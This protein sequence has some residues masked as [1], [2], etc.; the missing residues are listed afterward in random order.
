MTRLDEA[1]VVTLEWDE[2]DD[3][4]VFADGH[5]SYEIDENCEIAVFHGKKCVEVKQ[6]KDFPHAV[7]MVL[8]SEAVCSYNLRNG[9]DFNNRKVNEY[10]CVIK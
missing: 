7:S 4:N 3:G 6:A 5:Q 8:A 1:C 9:C 2:D 10:G